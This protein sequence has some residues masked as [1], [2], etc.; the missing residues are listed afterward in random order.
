MLQFD[1]LKL[2]DRWDRC[3][4]FTPPIRAEQLKRKCRGSEEELQVLNVF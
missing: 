2:Q 4:A 1:G 3:V